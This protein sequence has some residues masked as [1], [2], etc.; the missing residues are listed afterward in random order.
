MWTSAWAFRAG[1]AGATAFLSLTLVMLAV[2]GD[3]ADLFRAAPGEIGDS[4][5]WWNGALAG[6]VTPKTANALARDRQLRRSY[7]AILDFSADISRSLA[8]R[9]DVPQLEEAREMLE[10]YRRELNTGG[11]S[12]LGK[13]LFGLGAKDDSNSTDQSFLDALTKP[14]T[15]ALS[16]IGSAVAGDLA[17]PAM[18]LGVGVGEGAA[19]GLK[20]ATA[21]TTKQVAGKVVADNG[22]EATGLNPAVQ[23]LGLGTS[24]T[25]LGAVNISSLFGSSTVDL[26]AVVLA[27]AE[28][29]GNGTASGLRLSSAAD[30]LE[31]P[32]GSDLPSLAGTLG[33]GVTKTVA[34]SVNLSALSANGLDISSLTGGTPLSVIA[35]SLAQGIGNGTA[36]GLK[37]VSTPITP[38]SGSSAADTLGAFGFGLTDSITRNIDLK[39]ISQSSNFNLGSVVPDIGAAALSFGQGLGNGTTAGLKLSTTAT[40][41]DTAGSDIPSIAGNFAFGLSKSVTE[42]INTSSLFSSFSGPNTTDMLVKFLPSAASGLGKGL[43]EGVSVGLGL[44]PES[45]VA[46]QT[47]SNGT[48]DVSG[49]VES[50]AMGLSSRLLAN[51]SITKLLSSTGSKS[52]SEGSLLLSGTGSI[53]IGKVAQ[54]FAIGLVQGAGDAIDSM[55]G[56]EALLNGTATTPTGGLPN[57]TL[58]FNDTVDGAATGFGQGLGGQGALVAQQLISKLNPGAQTSIST[59]TANASTLAVST[60]GISIRNSGP[61]PIVLGRRQTTTSSGSSGLN[62][63]III[64]ADTV[65][66]VAQK[67]VDA[68]TCQ[69]VGGLLSVLQGLKNSGVIPTNLPANSSGNATN[70]I[71]EAIPTGLIRVKNEG[72]VYELDGQKV[73]GALGG[74]LT[75]AANGVFINGNTVVKF[76]VFLAIH[77]LAATVAFLNIVPLALGLESSRNIL[78]RL[79]L[80]HVMPNIPRWNTVLWLYAFTPFLPLVLVFGILAMGTA[81]HFR[82]AHGVLG[83]L[84]IV[85]AIAAVALHCVVKLRRAEDG[86]IIAR[87]FKFL[88]PRTV[89]TIVNQ[90]LLIVSVAT[91]FTGFADLSVISLCFTQLISFET[92]VVLGFSLSGALMLGSAVSGLDIFLAL[93]EC[94]RLRSSG[95]QNS[96]KAGEGFS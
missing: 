33:F 14:L 63:S 26:P 53:K 68:L 47:T 24:A 62:L 72:N 7:L 41:P 45:A 49:V 88:D 57:T 85:L 89:R 61:S 81:G 5:D 31:P 48:I 32:K 1:L 30:A 40:S 11:N 43:G 16:G 75:S 34:S 80:S 95:S 59:S 38:P 12:V 25:L 67:G 78:I 66:A 60:R 94:R 6:L 84:T 29:I 76:L 10:S 44:Q 79:R 71:E 18:F 9:Y 69:G 35:L 15:S 52:A 23:N 27:A 28:G 8:A 21:A 87:P 92:T 37:L 86:L 22:M 58:A 90:V 54:G 55:G 50:F 3:F 46:I 74:G 36:S 2:V 91:A 56:V 93:R 64:N 4:L 13:R 20:L 65:S 82:T 19:Q 51:G 96:G 17:G 70:F 73:V 42:N 77:I 83:I 39:A